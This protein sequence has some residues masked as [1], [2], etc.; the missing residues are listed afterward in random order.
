[1]IASQMP[2]TKENNQLKDPHT[3]LSTEHR[4]IH[5]S[6]SKS[7][8]IQ[9]ECFRHR[10]SYLRKL[11]V[12]VFAIRSFLFSCQ[13]N[14]DVPNTNGTVRNTRDIYAYTQKCTFHSILRVSNLCM[15]SREPLIGVFATSNVHALNSNLHFIP[16]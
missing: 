8:Q 1:M 4:N 13:P 15:P 14:G 7:K 3:L 2:S 12:I 5:D 10:H 11:L 16:P 6:A 9:D